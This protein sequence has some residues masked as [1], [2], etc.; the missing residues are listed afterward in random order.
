MPPTSLIEAVADPLRRDAEGGIRKPIDRVLLV[1]GRVDTAFF[2]EHVRGL[3]GITV[4]P[5]AWNGGK[6]FVIETCRDNDDHHGVVDMDHDFKSLDVQHERVTDTSESCNLFSLCIGPQ[7]REESS[8]IARDILRD[9]HID[10]DLPRPWTTMFLNHHGDNFNKYV[11]ERTDAI[12]FRG[13]SKLRAPRGTNE[14]TKAQIESGEEGEWVIDLI[15]YES[16]LG[17]LEFKAKWGDRLAA[18]GVNDHVLCD[19]LLLLLEEFGLQP[20]NKGRTKRQI[21]ER[22]TAQMMG[23]QSGIIAQ[24]LLMQ[25]GI[26]KQGSE[27]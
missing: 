1:E 12:L 17:F 27:E 26:I 6:D 10:E 21:E 11:C 24:R 13:L 2:K 8:S 19:A 3:Q 22:L 25:T 23:D 20:R 5:S 16:R 18:A 14:T 4:K 15:P 7:T 9:I